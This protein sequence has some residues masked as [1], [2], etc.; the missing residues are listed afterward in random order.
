VAI[1]NLINREMLTFQELHEI[2]GDTR[3]VIVRFN[4]GRVISWL[5][6]NPEIHK[7]LGLS[8]P[9]AWG[10]LNRFLMR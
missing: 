7:K 8:A 4:K 10:C 3:I 9:Y 1:L 6:D 2:I 5:H